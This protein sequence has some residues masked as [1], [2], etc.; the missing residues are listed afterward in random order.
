MGNKYTELHL[1][2]LFIAQVYF[3]QEYMYHETT[4]RVVYI[5]VQNIRVQ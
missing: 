5:R 4:G 3:A 2:I 1:L